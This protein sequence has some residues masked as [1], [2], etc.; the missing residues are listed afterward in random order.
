MRGRKPKPTELKILHGNPGK[1]PLN[2]REPKPEKGAPSCPPHI[3]KDKVAA[4]EWR[5]II[6]VLDAMG[7]LTKADRTALALYCE[8][9]SRWIE[10]GEQVKKIGMVVKNA[11]TGVVYQSP[12]LAIVNKAFE[13]IQKF[14]IEFGMT[15]SSRTRISVTEEP[16]YEGS[17]MAFA[18]KRV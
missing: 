8:A 17:V 2:D 16:S 14:L 6:K 12:Y 15:P 7:L 13:Q 18:R 9:Y 1:R 4:R 10:A 5:S 3:R 11:Q